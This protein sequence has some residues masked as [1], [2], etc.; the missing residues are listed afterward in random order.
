MK[1]LIGLQS[2]EDFSLYE[3]IENFYPKFIPIHD[4]SLAFSNSGQVV[5]L[6]FVDEDEAIMLLL[7][8]KFDH[9]DYE[10]RISLNT[11]IVRELNFIREYKVISIY[12]TIPLRRPSMLREHSDG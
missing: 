1:K 5:S 6:F 10:S 11:Y 2:K 3:P 7:S 4:L 12:N 9:A 8:G